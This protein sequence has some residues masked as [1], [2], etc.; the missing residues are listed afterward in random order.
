MSKTEP[1]KSD[2][3]S[4]QYLL[5]QLTSSLQHARNILKAHDEMIKLQTQLI[6]QLTNRVEILEH[7]LMVEKGDI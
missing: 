3:E 1:E 2:W 7:Q 4:L 6:N 5:E